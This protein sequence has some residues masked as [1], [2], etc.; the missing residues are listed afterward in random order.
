MDKSKIGSTEDVLA[1]IAKVKAKKE[2]IWNER[3]YWVAEFIKMSKIDIN[4][5]KSVT[6]N[7]EEKA[8]Q[9][10]LL[11]GKVTNAEN[12]YKRADSEIWEAICNYLISDY[13]LTKPVA[14]FVTKLAYEKGRIDGYEECFRC[15]QHYGGIACN[16]QSCQGE[17][18]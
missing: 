10:K 15:A 2:V 16:I 12:L 8:N 13:S 1:V 7:L 5:E 3:R 18:G 6:C 11:R 4:E 14:E 9:L 17:I